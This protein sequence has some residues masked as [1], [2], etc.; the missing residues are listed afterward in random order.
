MKRLIS[1]FVLTLTGIACADVITI[2]GD[3]WP[4]YNDDPASATP[5]Y[6]V[7]LA[8][9]IFAKK[10]HEVKY[11]MVPWSRA[12]DGVTKG[13]Y[14]GAIGAMDGDVPGGVLS[15]EP[16]GVN[17]NAFYAKKGGTWKYT[18]IPSLVNKQVGLIKDYTYDKGEFDTWAASSK[19]VGW[20][21]GDTPLLT[22]LKKIEAGRLDLTVEDPNVFTWIVKQNKLSDKFE[23]VGSLVTRNPLYISFSPANP[24][25]KEYAKILSDG[26]A[27]MRA[28]G[29]LKALLDKYGLKDWK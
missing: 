21:M 17:H 23:Q 7:E 24:K 11:V 14:T 13:T 15:T 25:S 28:N 4:P 5:G 16:I 10:N 8:K 19:T 18:G 22:N 2:V 1:T 6:V 26:I 20:T 29:K 12:V 9:E 27:E 3:Q